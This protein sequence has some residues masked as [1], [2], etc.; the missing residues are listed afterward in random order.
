MEAVGV[1]L[2]ALT[3]PLRNATVGLWMIGFGAAL[4]VGP[5]AAA[6]AVCTAGGP[7]GCTAYGIGAVPT[8]G[9]GGVLVYAGYQWTKE[10]T[11]PSFF[12]LYN[13]IFGP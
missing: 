5:I 13:Q 8:I 1:G 4:V 3:T 9:G 2:N 7:L 10:A 11:L 6:P 12:N